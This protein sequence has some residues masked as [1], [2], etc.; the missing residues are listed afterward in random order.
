MK[1][2]NRIYFLSILILATVFLNSCGK[3]GKTMG[4]TQSSQSL[5]V[6]KWT[7]QQEKYVQYIDGVKKQDTVINASQN[8]LALVQFN[9]DGTFT[10]TSSYL[11]GVATGSLNSGVSNASASTSGTYSF[12]GTVFSMSSYVTGLASGNS[13]FYGFTTATSIP[14]Y[15]A[16]S[17][18]MQINELTANRLNLHIEVIYTLT[19]NSVPQTYKTVGDYFYTR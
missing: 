4:L 10:S 7:L 17:S 8:N 14:V 3:G 18:A 9:K 19:I 13:S 6:G 12:A 2:M 11:S 1:H 15:S 5:I 16:V